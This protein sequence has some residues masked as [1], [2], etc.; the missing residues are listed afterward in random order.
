[1][2]TTAP[3]GTFDGFVSIINPSTGAILHSTYIGTNGTDHAVAIQNDCADNIYVLGRTTGNYPISS[4]VWTTFSDGDIFVDKLNMDLSASLVS[5]RLGN[6]QSNYSRF[7][8]S[9]FLVDICGRIYIAGFSAQSGLPLTP[10]AFQT[11]SAS[12]WFCTLE[13]NFTD[14]DYASYFGVSGDHNHIGVNR[15]D[16][17]GAV[18]HSVCNISQYP[19]TAS[20]V[21]SPSKQTSGQDIVSFKFN[22]DAVSI[23]L[24]EATGS[25]GN[26][27]IPHCVRGCKSAYFDFTRKH[28]DTIPLT[29]HYL[30]GGSAVR[31]QD[32]QWI[33]DSIVIPAYDT[34]ATLEIKPL[35][36]TN[37]PTGMK[38]VIISALS[39][40]G[41]ENG[42]DNVVRVGTVRIYDSLYVEINTPLDTVCSN[43]PISITANIDTSLNFQWSP[44]N[45]I[46]DPLPLGLTIHPVPVHTTTYSITVTQPDALAT[47]PPHKVSYPI[48]VEPIPQIL[49][50][51]KDTTVCLSDSIDL[52][53][54]GKPLGTDYNFLWTP[55][56][57]LRQ[58]D[59]ANNKFYAPVGDYK[60]VI[61]ATTPWALCQS[62][63]SFMIHVVPPFQFSS[64]T[65]EDTLIKRG[66]S[67]QLHARGDANFWLWSPVTYLN[68]PTLEDPTARPLKSTLYTLVGWDKYGCKDTAYVNIN[69]EYQ[70]TVIM[71]NAFSPNGDGRNDVFKIEGLK[72]EKLISFKIFNRLGQ[73]IFDAK[74]IDKGWNGTINGKPAPMDTYFYDVKLAMPDGTHKDI[75]GDLTLIR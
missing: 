65:P 74:S 30:I 66:D 24:K 63:D 46:P 52:N 55:A 2:I 70:S 27:T 26:D 39:P 19:F 60:Y 7:F 47:C 64:V 67:V 25:G 20:N 42:T 75:K 68:D 31:G 54:Y 14:V 21:W 53:V 50:P 6:N 72:D 61:T 51:T 28:A 17:N 56:A 36:V 22:F 4:G 41:C 1:M 73:L 23:G 35:I 45:L 62:K 57:H 33:P 3:G 16:P 8:P 32:Y 43:T 58:G 49:L 29:I 15:M 13:P 9:A 5:T 71:P 12:F 34:I 69:V 37:M 44:E 38:D 10:D 40:C 48:T 11:N 18:Y 59:I